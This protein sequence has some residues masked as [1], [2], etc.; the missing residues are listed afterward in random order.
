MATVAGQQRAEELSPRAKNAIWGAFLGFFVDMFDIYLPVVV[1]AP[2]LIYFVSPQLDAATSA[3]VGASIFAAT[4]VGRPLGAL[5]F[6]RFADSI[7]RR[8]TTIIAVSGFGVATLLMALLPGYEQIGLAAVIVFIVLRFVDGIFLGGEYTSASPLAMEYSPREKRGL[9]GALIM[10]GFP[11]AYAFISL[12][13]MFLLFWLPAEGLNSPYVQWG[14]R[15]PFFFGAFLAFAF[16]A[17]YYYFVEESEIWEQSGGNEAPIRTLFSGDNLKNFLQVFV[18]MTG[19]WLTLNTI[20]AILPGLLGDPIGLSSTNVTITLVIANVVLVGGYVAAGV[21]SQ[22]TGRRPFL[23]VVGVVMAVAATF[24]YYLLISAAPKSLFLVILLTTLITVLIVSPW[25][26]ATTYINERFHTG[27]RA[28]GFGLGYSL[29]VVIPS[30]YAF[31]QAGLQTF[32]PAEY[33]V[34]V[35]LVVGALLI[36][37]GAAWG[38]ETKDVDFSEDAPAGSG[39][40][41]RASE[42]PPPDLRAAPGA[43]RTVG[44][45]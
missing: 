42:A 13:T 1:L 2:A 19:F 15:I 43:D 21:I 32:M 3:I 8:R 23:M 9:Y 20:S 29:A 36:V 37:A 38:P 26:L 35:L 12:I 30:F 24:L 28:S 40:G 4:L 14:W 6:G 39:A 18:M 22:R 33:T 5:I 41:E 44:G 16:V 27:V 11:L 10:T 17:Y 31:Y 25:G 34:L 7:G 45:A